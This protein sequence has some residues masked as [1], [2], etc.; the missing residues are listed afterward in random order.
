MRIAY[1][2]N[3]NPE[4]I[5]NWSGTPYHIISALRK[6]HEV[7]W[8]GGG[9]LYG[10]LW[11]HRF[12][13]KKTPFNLL[14]YIDE[15]GRVVSRFIQEGN[16]DIAISSTYSICAHLDIDIPLIAFS[17]L[18]YSLCTTYLKKT[19]PKCQKERAMQIENDF[20]QLADAVIYPSLFA[21]NAAL[22]DYPIKE[23]KIH[24]LDF[25]ANIPNPIDVKIDEYK[26]DVCQ[27]V[28]VGRNWIRKGGDKAL[29]A[30][31]FLKCQGFPCELT[32][33]GCEPTFK[34]E[35]KG[36][37]VIPWL[38]KSNAADMLRY[39]K[40]MR[41]SHFMILPTEFDAYGIVFCEAS[42]YGVPSLATNVGGVSQPIRDGVNGF[43]F[44]PH[45][46]AQEYAEKIK[47]TFLDKKM[48]KALR[49]NSR[50]EYET[51]LNWEVWSKAMS[52]IMEEILHD[53]Q[54]K[55][56]RKNGDIP[57]MSESENEISANQFYIPI[58]TFNLKSRPD[59]LA[60]IRQQFKDKP[61]FKVTPIEAVRHENGAV[62]LWQ[63]ICKAISVAQKR[64]EDIIIL[65]EDDHEFT[66]YYAQDYLFSNIMEAYAQG[67]ELLNGGIGGF[68][69][70][71]PVAANRSCVDWFWCTQF[72]VV[73]A[74][75]FPKILNYDF[76]EGDTADGVLSQIASSPQVMYPPVSCQK[77]FGYSDITKQ[78]NPMFQDNIFRSCNERLAR[79]HSVYQKHQNGTKRK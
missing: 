14:D 49:Y 71:V 34:V 77:N 24:V 45:A 62:G 74:P 40:I 43:L 75:L 21:K 6:F 54:A 52:R 44:S 42:A 33:I 28:F 58:Y 5:N 13:D 51:R 32:I 29:S 22:A 68:G 1:I 23:D 2:S 12:L 78:R 55:G 76:R 26:N 19:A 25:G 27:L 20:L 15:M 39:D 16:Y 79:I 64:D 8:V 53:K 37:K 17:D 41:E 61:E 47:A 35:D 31:S 60:H 30:Y 59:R 38:D 46:T 63:S 70:A 65:C 36:V 67:A 7:D 18:T 57:A 69:N 48:Y 50:R 9:T 56:A 11:Y 4:D 66:P 72:V 73:F 3:D 10:A